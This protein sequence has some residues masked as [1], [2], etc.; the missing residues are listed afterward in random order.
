[1]PIGA[2]LELRSRANL[3]HLVKLAP[4]F[5]A[6]GRQR[7]YALAQW[8]P[9]M[10]LDFACL[11]CL[12]P[13]SDFGV[14]TGVLCLIKECWG[15]SRKVVGNLCFSWVLKWVR[16][17]LMRDLLGLS[18]SGANNPTLLVIYGQVLPRCTFKDPAG[19]V[20][21]QSAAPGVWSHLSKCAKTVGK[22]AI[23]G[24]GSNIFQLWCPSSHRFWCQEPLYPHGLF[25]QTM[26]TADH[27][28]HQRASVWLGLTRAPVGMADA[29]QQDQAGFQ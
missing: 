14:S 10:F 17:D 29:C 13:I 9:T 6:W 15:C 19:K 16:Q 1:M 3:P 24:M 25:H 18:H 2:V 21:R 23:T 26:R 22:E 28:P 4:A 11:L 5:P 7:L 27:N 12:T 8:F 20:A